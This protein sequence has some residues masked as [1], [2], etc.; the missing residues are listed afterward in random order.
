MKLVLSIV[1]LLL[2]SLYVR[3]QQDTIYLDN[4]MQIV[5]KRAKAKEC[6]MPQKD[7][8]FKVTIFTLS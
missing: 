6:A 3:A 1:L 8:F 7:K 4:N 2:G 5:K